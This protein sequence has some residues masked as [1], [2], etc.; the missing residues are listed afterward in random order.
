[1]CQ[2]ACYRMRG[3]LSLTAAILDD[4]LQPADFLPSSAQTNR[5]PSPVIFIVMNSLLWPI[6]VDVSTFPCISVTCPAD[7]LQRVAIN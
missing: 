7:P 1:M 3:S 6:G 5:W 4:D 2:R